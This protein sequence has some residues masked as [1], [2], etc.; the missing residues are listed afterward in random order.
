M[1]GLGGA[2]RHACFEAGSW[3]RLQLDH[4]DQSISMYLDRTTNN[5]SERS[6]RANSCVYVFVRFNYLIHNAVY[7]VIDLYLKDSRLSF[8]MCG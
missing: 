1:Y 6:K 7:D 2:R 3:L 4:V 8:K 5:A